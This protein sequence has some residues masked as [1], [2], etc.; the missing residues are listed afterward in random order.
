MKP[1]NENSFSHY[2]H[3]GTWFEC[4]RCDFGA[5][6]KVRNDNEDLSLPQL[7]SDVAE[8]IGFR[9]CNIWPELNGFQGYDCIKWEF[10]C[11]AFPTM[12]TLTVL[13]RAAR[14]AHDFKALL[15]LMHKTGYSKGDIQEFNGELLDE[16][17]AD[18]GVL[19]EKL[20]DVDTDAL[21][22]TEDEIAAVLETRRDKKLED[23]PIVNQTGPDAY[24]YCSGCGIDYPGE[25][26]GRMPYGRQT[27][28]GDNGRCLFCDYELSVDYDAED[29]E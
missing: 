9:T 8:M 20:A 2:C 10:N 14:L 12:K 18:A 13:Q 19:L 16:M 5:P 4:D 26:V 17:E 6:V 28:D 27:A 23:F 11:D 3:N 29:E 25:D 21:N 15:N 22:V 24:A 1:L 7:M